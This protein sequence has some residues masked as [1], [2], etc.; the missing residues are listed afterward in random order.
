MRTSKFN[1][2]KILL[3]VLIGVSTLISCK[4]KA[5]DIIIEVDPTFGQYISAYTSGMVSAN[6]TITIRFT[7]PAQKFTKAGDELDDNVFKISPSIDGKTYWV[8]DQTIEFKPT[9][10]LVSGEI[11]TIRFF[12]AKY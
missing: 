8:D 7:M 2:L 1:L 12:L 6:S 3:L 9:N 10:P 4:K 5:K 11:Y